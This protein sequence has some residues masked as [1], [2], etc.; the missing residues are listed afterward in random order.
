VL[1]GNVSKRVSCDVPMISIALFIGTAI[2]IFES[3]LGF[4]FLKRQE[5]SCFTFEWNTAT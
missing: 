5:R 1:L 3:V 2:E 4:Q